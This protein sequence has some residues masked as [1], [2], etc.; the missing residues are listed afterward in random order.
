MQKKTIHHNVNNNGSTITLN[1]NTN[2]VLNIGVLD[3]KF[4]GTII[5]ENYDDTFIS[6]KEIIKWYDPITD[7][8]MEKRDAIS[9]MIDGKS[10]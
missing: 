3:S 1:K 2:V 10:L 4:S 5:L 8:I 9:Y 7:S 6:K